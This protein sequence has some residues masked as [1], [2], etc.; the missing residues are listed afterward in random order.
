MA[1]VIVSDLTDEDTATMLGD[2]AREADHLVADRYN[3]ELGSLYDRLA[4]YPE[5]CQA[6]PKLGAHVRVGVIHPYLV[7][8]RY[9]TGSDTVSIVRILH[10]RR[11]ITRNFLRPG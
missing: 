10:R 1:R 6:R 5:S 9:A 4:D 2:I 11:K 3:A 7:I 8:Y